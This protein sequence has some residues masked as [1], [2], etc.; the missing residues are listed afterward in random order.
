M[1]PSDRRGQPTVGGM[2]GALTNMASMSWDT[3]T[4]EITIRRIDGWELEA[5][6]APT[7]SD[8]AV[9]V[10][11]DFQTAELVLVFDQADRVTASLA[12]E[13]TARERVAAQPVVYLDQC[14]WSAMAR[15]LT[16]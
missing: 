16:H 11:A 3:S 12:D 6:I 13:A 8:P 5:R 2:T 1:M 9:R 14:H 4:G 10:E 7:P 15:H